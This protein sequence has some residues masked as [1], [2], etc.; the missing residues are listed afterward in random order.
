MSQEM[1]ARRSAIVE[2]GVVT[3]QGEGVPFAKFELICKRHFRTVVWGDHGTIKKRKIDPTYISL[4][5]KGRDV[6]CVLVNLN[7]APDNWLDEIRA[8][9]WKDLSFAP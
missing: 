2:K 1:E 3:W 4:R 8:I 5:S 9:Y 7:T 6:R